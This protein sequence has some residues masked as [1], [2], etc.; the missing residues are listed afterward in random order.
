MHRA[1]RRCDGTSV[2]LKTVHIFEMGTHERNE[3]T[4]EIK[5]LQSM[6]HP[7]II[8]Y[9]DCQMEHNE[10]TVV[11][12]L[13]NHG[14]LSNLLRAAVNSGRRLPE[15][16]VWQLFAQIA[17]AL[18]YMHERR[19]MHR[20]IKPA[21]VFISSGEDNS[22]AQSPVLKLGDLGL[23]RY[24]SSKTD[25]THSTVGTPYYMSPECIRGGGYDF[26]SDVWSLGC[27]LY[28]LAALRSPFYAPALNFY[29]LG[30]RIVSRQFEP[31]DLVSD[32][33]VQS[34]DRMLQVDSADRL[35]AA[36]V[37]SLAERGEQK[38]KRSL[39]TI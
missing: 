2:A 23:G 14:D 21:N 34:V 1:C 24:F 13:A 27:L 26:K 8:R 28:E 4:N 38:N 22:Q 29:V 37:L 9:L 10:L 7:N 16:R 3:C 25:M 12:E 33:L 31:L 5:L 32:A 6:R 36:E 35:S 39:Y 17:G 18:A 15:A 20:D 19:V 30:K 11:M